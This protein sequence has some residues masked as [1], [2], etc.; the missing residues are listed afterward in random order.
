MKKKVII[1]TQACEHPISCGYFVKVIRR[2]I[3]FDLILYRKPV[4]DV[5]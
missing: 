2:T 1:Y 3:A 4:K 5:V